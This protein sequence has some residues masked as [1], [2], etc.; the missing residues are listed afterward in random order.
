MEEYCQGY[1]AVRSR[2]Q[3]CKGWRK[4]GNVISSGK[5]D[6]SVV[7]NGPSRPVPVQKKPSDTDQGFTF[8]L[9]Q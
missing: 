3:D 6:A 7:L 8:P 9:S 4:V 5:A 1:D 2:Y